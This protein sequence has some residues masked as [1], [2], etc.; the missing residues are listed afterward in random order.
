VAAAVHNALC[1]SVTSQKLA[2]AGIYS[3][4]QPYPTFSSTVEIITHEL[5]HLLNSRHT[6]ACVWN[7]NNTAIDG[8]SGYVENPEGTGV[9]DCPL[10]EDPPDGGTIMSYCEF[11][12]GVNFNLGFGP[13]PGNVIRASYNSASC[14]PTVT[15]SGPADYPYSQ[16]ASYS[17]LLAGTWSVTSPLTVYSGQGTNSIVLST[18]QISPVR[19]ATLSLLPKGST[20]EITKQITI[21]RD[22]IWSSG[23]PK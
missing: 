8:C 9:G 5:G 4:Y 21:P 22:T 15:I 6:H 10:P 19:Y 7:G 12:A 17:S 20:T 1:L 18:P 3:T 16:F 11:T 23:L 2:V 14:L 13:Q